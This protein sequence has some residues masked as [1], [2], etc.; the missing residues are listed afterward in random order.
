MKKKICRKCLLEK[1]VCE[2]YKHPKK[3]NDVRNTCKVCMNKNSNNHYQ[4]N[5]ESEKE[6]RKKY[7]KQYYLNNKISENI[8]SKNYRDNNLEKVKEIQRLSSKKIRNKDLE[9]SNNYS[10]EWR[11]KNPRYGVM[12]NKNRTQNDELFK[13]KT[14]V[15]NRIRDFLKLKKITKKNNT[16]TILGCTPQILKEHLEGKFVEGM[17]WENHGL[18]G[19]HI[20][21]IIP[22]SSAKTEEEIL[23]L[24]HYKNLQ[25]LWAKDNLKKS[26][27]IFN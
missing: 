19:W 8:R 9:K 11:K 12:Y 4:E 16:F 26:N 2:F 20:D 27:K 24:C 5:I 18:F 22:L 14:T 25:P 7:Q 17:S 21:H 15:R 1:G 23:K 3:E 6:R 13:L 10:R